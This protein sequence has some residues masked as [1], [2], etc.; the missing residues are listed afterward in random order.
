MKNNYNQLTCDQLDEAYEYYLKEIIRF[1]DKVQNSGV[2]LSH[3]EKVQATTFL[4][5]LNKIR[6]TCGKKAVSINQIYMAYLS[7]YL[8]FF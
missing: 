1:L 3:K 6:K 5:E 7:I 4:Y 8:K 2:L